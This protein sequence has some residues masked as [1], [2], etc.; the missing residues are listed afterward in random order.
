MWLH[1]IVCGS[2]LCFFFLFLFCFTIHLNSCT[3][4]RY[5]MSLTS[6]AILGMYGSYHLA[7]KGLC[8]LLFAFDLPFYFGRFDFLL[9][10]ILHDQLYMT[11]HLFCSWQ[12]FSFHERSRKLWKLLKTVLSSHIKV[13]HLLF[14]PYQFNF[15]L[16]LQNHLQVLCWSFCCISRCKK[17]YVYSFGFPFH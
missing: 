14:C 1:Y 13:H 10:T 12:R 8:M 2:Y 4:A 6:W 17:W 16:L 5:I 3:H 9:L 7:T 15:S 11:S